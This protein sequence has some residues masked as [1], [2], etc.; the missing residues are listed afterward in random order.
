MNNEIFVNPS[1]ELITVT[2][3]VAVL[4]AETAAALYELEAMGKYIEDVKKTLKSAILAEMERKNI[5]GIDTDDLTIR[6]VEEHYRE[7]FNKR[8]MKKEHA[9]LYD[10]Y[11]SMGTVA[12]SLRI[13]LKDNKNNE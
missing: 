10:Q 13:K 6:Y 4:N 2:D 9:D 7:N 5:I 12:A 11:V 3:G 8:A 1:E